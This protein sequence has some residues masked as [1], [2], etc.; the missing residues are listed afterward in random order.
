MFE[1]AVMDVP[2]DVRDFESLDQGMEFSNGN[3][4]PLFILNDGL[5]RWIHLSGIDSCD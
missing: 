3:F 5:D 4:I 2:Q 1:D